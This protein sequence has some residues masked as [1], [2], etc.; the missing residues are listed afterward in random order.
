MPKNFVRDKQSGLLEVFLEKD[1]GNRITYRLREE[2]NASEE[3]FVKVVPEDIHLP[4]LVVAVGV[5]DGGGYGKIDS[6]NLKRK[7]PEGCNAYFTGEAV[8]FKVHPVVHIKDNNW[9]DRYPLDMK[10][11]IRTG[12][13]LV[14]FCRVPVAE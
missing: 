12:Y 6:E 7:R 2:N 3:G 13:I 11:D 4:V 10:E 8:D 5:G 1:K 14:N 9:G